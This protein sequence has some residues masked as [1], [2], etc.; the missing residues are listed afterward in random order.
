[1]LPISDAVRN[2]RKVLHRADYTTL[3]LDV[4]GQVTTCF[5]PITKTRPKLWPALIGL[6]LRG[7]DSDAR[8][9]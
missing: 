7:K 2:D 1:M 4:V 6:E 5:E 8:G 3:L 9:R